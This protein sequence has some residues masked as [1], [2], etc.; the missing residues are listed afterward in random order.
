MKRIWLRTGILQKT[1][2]EIS[3][4]KT[5]KGGGN[6]RKGCNHYGHSVSSTDIRSRFLSG[7]FFIKPFHH[8]RYHNNTPSSPWARKRGLWVTHDYGN[9]LKLWWSL[10]FINEQRKKVKLP[11]FGKLQGEIGTSNFWDF[12]RKGLLGPHRYKNILRS[13]HD[14]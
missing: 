8:A 6:R 7:I 3:V 14:G 13:N 12:F 1:I 10:A 2:K 4:S 5:R 11:Q 9:P